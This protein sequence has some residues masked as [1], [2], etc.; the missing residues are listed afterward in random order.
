VHEN[1]TE[2]RQRRKAQPPPIPAFLTADA[3]LTVREVAAWRRCGVSTVWRDVK[4]GTLPPPV[5]ITPKSP[6]WRWSELLAALEQTRALPR[7][8]MAR[9]RA[10]K[11]AGA[12]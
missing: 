12:A 4:R 7:E 10:A 11:M 8:A 1:T 6:R 3:L 9:R 2:P 5:Y